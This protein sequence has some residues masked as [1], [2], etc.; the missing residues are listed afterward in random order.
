MTTDSRVVPV[1]PTLKFCAVRDGGDEWHIE[2]RMSDGQKGA[3]VVVDKEF[4]ALAEQVATLLNNASAP[5]AS[6]SPDYLAPEDDTKAKR[7]CKCEFSG[8]GFPAKVCAYHLRPPASATGWAV[9]GPDLEIFSC[10]TDVEDEAWR[11]AEWQSA[12]SNAELRATGCTCH[13]V[14]ITRIEGE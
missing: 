2:C 7:R 11:I 9:F 12:C 14:A 4:E 6:A 3:F 13:R 10:S 5:P 1:E 8:G